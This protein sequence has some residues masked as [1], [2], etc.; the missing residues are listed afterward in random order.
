[1]RRQIVEAFAD[2]RAADGS[3]RLTNEF[4]ILIAR[5]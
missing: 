1:M 5:A 2:R 3:Y 4:R